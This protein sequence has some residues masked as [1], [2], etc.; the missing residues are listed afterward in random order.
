MS[1]NRTQPLWRQKT[2]QLLERWATRNTDR[3]LVVADAMAEQAISAG[4][5]PPEMF[6]TVYSGMETSW[7]DPARF[8]R[9]A[10]RAQFGFD[11]DAIVVGSVARLF[12]NKGYEQLIPAMHRAIQACPQLRFVWVGDGSSRQAYEDQLEANGIRSAVHLTG[13][14]PP[15][16]V[17][18]ILAG[19]D[20]LVH[21]SQW[22]GL[23]RAIVQALL[24]SKPVV[25]FDIDGAPEVVQP[26]HTGLL[27]PLNN[28]NLLADS[29]VKLAGD[30][31]LR[32]GMGQ[33][34]RSLCLERFDHELMVDRIEAVYKELA[35]RL[36]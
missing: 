12:P 7:Y 14:V 16:Q 35:N 18:E 26:G 25:S 5:A 6:T 32:A 4:I 22:E 8:D 29:I 17:A 11:S 13:L 34:G 36:L 1:F 15:E 30:S 33:A 24:M 28:I 31:A 2:Y 10:V 19:V 23:P 27:V 20:M 9:E 21:A 3:V